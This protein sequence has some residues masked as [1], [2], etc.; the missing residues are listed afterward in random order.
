MAPAS[1]RNHCTKSEREETA[2]KMNGKMWY[3][4]Y[5]HRIR[6][7]WL[8]LRACLNMGKCFIHISLI[9]VQ[10]STLYQVP[11]VKDMLP[12][13]AEVKIAAALGAKDKYW[14]TVLDKE[15]THLTTSCT[16]AGSYRWLGMLFWIKPAVEEHFC[17]QE[18]VLMGLRDQRCGWWH[19]AV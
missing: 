1:L 8:E 10:Q 18:D 13:L 15:S 19:S 5:G 11:A 6:E 16:P 9:K 7:H 4:S 3:Q 14:Q 17:C 2:I 12:D